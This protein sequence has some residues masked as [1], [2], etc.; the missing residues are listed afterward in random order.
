M[1]TATI[2]SSVRPVP[3]LPPGPTESPLVQAVEF[4]RDPYGYFERC[5]KRYGDL[6]TFRLPLDPPRVVTSDPALVRTIFALG[7]DDFE[8]A[9]S[10]LPVN[11]GEQSLIFLDGDRHAKERRLMTPH[12]HGERLRGYAADMRAA[13]AE[14]IAGWR[15][16]EE[17]DMRRD[18]KVITLNVILRCVF[19]LHDEAAARAIRKPLLYWLEGVFTSAVFTAGMLLTPTRVRH[20]LDRS[21]ARGLAGKLG[22][23]IFPW[24]RWAEA[25]VSVLQTLRADVE[26]CRREGTNGRT[27]LLALF[28]EARYEDGALMEVD[29][30]VDELVMMLVG[31]HETTAGTLAWALYHIVQRPDVVARIR[32]E[33]QTTFGDGPFDPS[34]AGELAY[35][36]ACLKESMR[37]T[38][39][40]PA[41]PRNIKKPLKLRGYTLPPGTI[42]W[43]AV[44]LTHHRE[45]LWPDPFAFKPE[46]FLGLN[47]PQNHFFPFGGGRRA[48][49][50]MAFAMTEMRIVLA[51][52]LR[53]VDLRLLPGAAK[54]E[55]RGI[56]IVPNDALRFVMDRSLPFSA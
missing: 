29:A 24:E 37:R 17:L 5:T 45:D 23:P 1:T 35:L 22:K 18:L 10:A 54:P 36:D 2:D 51:E 38:P 19:G 49:L 14:V 34:R 6:F 32:E 39:I 42:V 13:A 12:L 4:G 53:R 25:K 8:H 40:T 9:R 16:G 21:V 33:I 7:A 44:A 11:I 20:L 31:G 50:G 56:T 30:I 27:D 28:T 55:F 26:R 46:R 43:A 3:G 41:S 48:C 15:P 47:A 52:I